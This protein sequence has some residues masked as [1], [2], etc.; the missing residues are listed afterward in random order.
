MQ[1]INLEPEFRALLVHLDGS[2][3]LQLTKADL[4]AVGVTNISAKLRI[5]QARDALMRPR[6]A[7]I[8]RNAALKR[9]LGVSLDA[10]EALDAAVIRNLKP[11]V[12]HLLE[13]TGLTQYQP[14][15]A[16]EG[17][18]GGLGRD[19]RSGRRIL[20]MEIQRRACEKQ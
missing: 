2:E 8:A 14:L 15:F 1:H 9:A 13:S 10:G 3:L 20:T 6:A 12:V 11:D 17:E 18:A 16:A 5:L 4:E 19:G 7:S